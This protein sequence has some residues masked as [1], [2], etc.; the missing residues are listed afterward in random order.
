[1]NA[2]GSE[3]SPPS[4]AGTG[5]FDRELADGDQKPVSSNPPLP[6]QAEILPGSGSNSRNG[7]ESDEGEY[8]DE[9]TGLVRLGSYLLDTKRVG[10]TSSGR[11]AG[12]S[13]DEL[14]Q[15]SLEIQQEILECDDDYEAELRRADDPD[16]GDSWEAKVQELD[17]KIDRL[18]AEGDAV[19]TLLER[20]F[21]VKGGGRFLVSNSVMLARK[22]GESHGHLQAKEYMKQLDFKGDSSGN[23]D[24]G[25]ESEGCDV[26]SESEE[27]RTDL[28]SMDLDDSQT[29]RIKQSNSENKINMES[30]EDADDEQT[31]TSRQQASTI[32]KEELEEKEVE[33]QEASPGSKDPQKDNVEAIESDAQR[34]SSR[35]GF[36]K[37][38]RSSETVSE[39]KG[40]GNTFVEIS[41]GSV[42]A[43]SGSTKIGT[44]SETTKEPIIKANNS[45]G[46]RIIPQKISLQGKEEDDN[47]EE[48]E[49]SDVETGLTRLGS[50][51][52]DV[53]QLRAEETDVERRTL[54]SQHG[55]TTGDC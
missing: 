46:R 9:E 31:E 34:D 50:Y 35:K 21:K 23:V 41:H 37:E 8:S 38:I 55:D 3:N 36:G 43:V 25:S 33:D 5:A 28:E 45:V 51:L 42:E 32:R 11:R 13:K 16:A 49:L 4:A 17:R 39:A 6:A 15:R 44:S 29:E 27:S 47:G 18:A 26:S 30:I 48:D 14:L 1:L 19:E 52:L 20:K 53:D 24:D 54:D 2:S 10:N 22:H 40:G 12:L 7:F